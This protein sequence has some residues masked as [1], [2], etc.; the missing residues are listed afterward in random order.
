MPTL[1]WNDFSSFGAV[2]K[3]CNSI[4]EFSKM[5]EANQRAICLRGPQKE[6]GLAMPKQFIII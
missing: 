4:G 1:R 3:V 5:I 6:K 2:M